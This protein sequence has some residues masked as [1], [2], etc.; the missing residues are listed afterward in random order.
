MSDS[1]YLLDP[2][3]EAILQEVAK[4]PDSV[5]LRVDR[6]KELRVLLAGGDTVVRSKT[7][8]SSAEKQLLEVHRDEAASVSSR[9]SPGSS[10]RACSLDQSHTPID[11]SGD[12]FPSACSEHRGKKLCCQGVF[13]SE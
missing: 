1:S 13:D 3:V 12:S 8:L 4:D 7:G 5:L 11:R 2:E 10:R 6:P 9:V